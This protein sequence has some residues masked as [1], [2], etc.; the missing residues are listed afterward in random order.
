MDTAKHELIRSND[1]NCA[2]R[3]VTRPPAG[4]K[5]SAHCFHSG[6]WTPLP[7]FLFAIAN[8]RVRPRMPVNPHD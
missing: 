3:F 4:H 1:A 7:E 8:A 2:N 5:I 6:F